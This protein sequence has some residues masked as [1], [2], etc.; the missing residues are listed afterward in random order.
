[1]TPLPTDLFHFFL[2][3]GTPAV[4]AWVVSELLEH[5]NW[6][7]SQD[8]QVKSMVVMLTHVA[9]GVISM[10]LTKNISADVIAQ[11]DP[12]YAVIVQSLTAFAGSQYWHT[13][14]HTDTGPDPIDPAHHPS[15]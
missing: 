13:T 8:A 3:L 14:K 7:K 10:V 2:F 5:L 9:L 12:V 4:A 1:M 11:L 6:F 15:G